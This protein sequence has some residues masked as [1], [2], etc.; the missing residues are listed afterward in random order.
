MVGSPLGS[1][2]T[3]SP[4]G[5]VRLAHTDGRY[6]RGRLRWGLQISSGLMY[7]RA[8]V[9]VLPGMHFVATHPV[10]SRSTGEFGRGNGRWRVFK[11]SCDRP[12][13]TSLSVFPHATDQPM[14]WFP[15]PCGPHDVPRALRPR[16]W[17][18]RRN[19]CSW[20]GLT[21]C[22]ILGRATFLCFVVWFVAYL[23]APSRRISLV[24]AESA[25]TPFLVR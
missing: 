13:P 12:H 19:S 10:L 15:T 14:F 20:I 24:L 23:C 7:S 9:S 4:D 17:S 22:Q 16:F 1:L 11:V 3:G 6:A 5:R 2:Q 8:T 18:W 21:P 25:S